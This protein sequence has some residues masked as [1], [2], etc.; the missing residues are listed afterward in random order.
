MRAPHRCRCVQV[1]ILGRRIREFPI[2]GAAFLDALIGKRVPDG[3]R[4]A[5]LCPSR[6]AFTNLV[7][8]LQSWRLPSLRACQV[9]ALVQR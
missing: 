5:E 1:N 8:A 4:K 7:R 6:R 3:E 2:R 9:L